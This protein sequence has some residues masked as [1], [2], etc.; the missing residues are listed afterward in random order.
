MLLSDI[1][2]LFDERGG[3]FLL[4]EQ[5]L[6]DL[7]KLDERPWYTYAY[8]QPLSPQGLARLLQPF[9]IGPRQRRQSGQQVLRGYWLSDF[10]E[11]FARYLPPLAEIA[12]S[13]TAA[14]RQD[15]SVL[16]RD[17]NRFS[18]RREAA[19]D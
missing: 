19:V 1:Q 3:Q 17:H 16:R 4:T 18:F 13:A 6:A 7:N 2:R 10:R 12:T 8:G 14:T 9:G 5:L 15:G 11:A